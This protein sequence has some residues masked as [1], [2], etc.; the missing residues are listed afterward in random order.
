MPTSTALG[1]NTGSTITGTQQIGSLAVVTATTVNYS[2][3]TNGGVTFWMG[4][5]E[6]L[7]Y[8]IGVPV[9]GGTQTTPIV[10][11]NAFLGFYRSLLKT[12]SSFLSMV[13]STFNQTFSDANSASSWLTTNGFWN[14]YTA[15]ADVTP[16]P[17]NWADIKLE[18]PANEYT[19]AVQQITGINTPITLRASWT[20]G[21]S[22]LLAYRIDNVAPSW[23]NGETLLDG[24]VYD[25]IL[26][27]EGTIII[28]NNQYV[29]FQPYLNA[30][31]LATR[32]ITITNVSDSNTIIDTFTSTYIFQS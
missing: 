14:S 18:E 16:N 3:I 12:D 4:P 31:G 6:E 1:Y 32:T 24:F 11:V 15:G 23:T 20:G 5:D 10:G 9:S 22:L 8:V 30:V 21:D 13:N 28:S 25:S 2:P 27:T 17:V 19:V 7:G 29:S 26:D